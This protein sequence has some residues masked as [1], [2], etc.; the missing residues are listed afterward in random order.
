[1]QTS[2]LSPQRWA[3]TAGAAYLLIIAIGFTCEM[4]ARGTL[5]VPGDP[6][7]TADR[8]IASM[9]LWRASVA[10]DVVMHVL[11]IP[12]MLAIYVLL[13]PVN[14][15]LALFALLSNV[16]QTSVLV[17][18]KLNLIMTAL[19]L[20]ST[21]AAA[22]FTP[23]Q[24][25]ALAQ[26]SIAAHEYG[27]ALG[28]VFFGMTC[29]VEGYLIARSGYLPR[30]LGLGMQLAGLCY[31]TNSFALIVAPDVAARLFPAVLLPP[32]FAELALATWLLV[33]GVDL[34]RWPG[35]RMASG[36]A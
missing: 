27:F 17:A 30:L 32:F 24:V 23:A 29:L 12:V 16:V 15:N 2:T 1:M 13:R 14:R 33:K 28:L 6:A 11:D 7:A 9:L 31:L 34:A 10:A 36:A 18:N 3:R 21:S 26:V 25:Q 22:A 5:M 20:G 19:L 35:D 4:I 8:I